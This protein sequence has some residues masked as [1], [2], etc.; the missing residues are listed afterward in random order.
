ME[1]TNTQ[2]KLIA[3]IEAE[4]AQTRAWVAESPTTRYGGEL[5]TDP[6]HWAEYDVFTVE[7]FEKSS[8]AGLISDA[9]KSAYGCRRRVDWKEHSL[10]ELNEMADFYCKEANDE[11]ER[12]EHDNSDYEAEQLADLV[13]LAESLNVSVEDLERWGVA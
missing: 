7:D 6:A 11:C 13:I 10:K 2:K 5:V 8:L 3:Y 9:S 12:E 4:N 1:Y